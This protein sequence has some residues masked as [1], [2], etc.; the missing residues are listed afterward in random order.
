MYNLQMLQMQFTP[1][2]Q[3]AP[4]PNKMNEM[5]ERPLV[6]C[7]PEYLAQL[8]KD[9]TSYTMVSSMFVHVERLLD[10]GKFANFTCVHGLCGGLGERG[11]A[12]VRCVCM[13]VCIEAINF[14]LCV[15][16]MCWNVVL[17]L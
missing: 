11:C 16:D 10:D 7:S 8:M 4:A 5:A 6:Q 12:G 17:C 14:G 15:W 3:A 13:C 2:P 9:K 1:P